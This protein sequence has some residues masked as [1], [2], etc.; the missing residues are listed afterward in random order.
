MLDT[1]AVQAT[2]EGATLK[3]RPAGVPVRA[4]AWLL[5]S[6]IRMALLLVFG[7]LAAFAGA[8]G[9]GFFLIAT[10]LLDWFYNVLFEV[11]RG[12][13]PGKRA[14]GL[15]VVHDNGTP[16]S[17]SASLLRNLLRVVDFL[18]FGYALGL[19]VSLFHPHAKRLGD[20]AAGTLVIYVDDPRSS[21]VSQ[22]SAEPA[23]MPPQALSYSA[24]QAVVAF[25][26]RAAQLSPERQVELAE[27]LKPLHRVEGEQAV[28]H[29]KGYARWIRGGE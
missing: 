13:T 9:S 2:A 20:I 22:E 12:T 23:F 1:L 16:M 27:L 7:V 8:T 15:A 28:Q 10:F 18:P 3:L 11:L 26:E 25:A 14:M 29:L 19:L 17:W 6:L 4:L 5:D 21:Q 24:Q